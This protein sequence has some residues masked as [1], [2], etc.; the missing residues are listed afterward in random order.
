[1]LTLH[2]LILNFYFSILIP[3]ALG[4][5]IYSFSYAAVERWRF[6]RYVI[7]APWVMLQNEHG[8][9]VL[10][11]ERDDLEREI[12]KL[13]DSIVRGKCEEV[14]EEFPASR[15]DLAIADPPYNI[16]EKRKTSKSKGEMRTM[17]E[18]TEGWEQKGEEEYLSWV[19]RWMAGLYRLLRETGNVVVFFDRSGTTYLRDI[20][21]KLGLH[22]INKYYLGKVNPPPRAR[23]NNFISAVEEA[24]VFAKNGRKRKFNWLE[25]SKRMKNFS[26]VAV[27]EQVTDHPTE[28]PVSALRDLVEIFTDSD[29]IVL[30]PFSGSGSSLVA[31]KQAGRNYLG[32][33]KKDEYVEMAKK[34]LQLG[35]EKYGKRNRREKKLEKQAEGNRK[36]N[37]FAEEAKAEC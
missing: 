12:D 30:D 7:Y 34:R 35:N 6:E 24:V 5:A 15:I 27:N 19:E 18:I 23:K 17:E 14:M 8:V 3:A 9:V 28:K 22:P 21:K 31:A 25:D 33:E 13:R 32:I 16:G 26:L 36:L 20:G 10:D 1:M 29:D 11:A 37:E 2:S 4:Y